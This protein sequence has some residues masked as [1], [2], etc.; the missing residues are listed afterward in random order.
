M[1]RKGTSSVFIF[2]NDRSCLDQHLASRF[3]GDVSAVVCIFVCLL[4]TPPTWTKLGVCGCGS[5]VM[6]PE[7]INPREG[8]GLG[9][10]L[11]D[12]EGHRKMPV[13]R[14]CVT[15][16]GILLKFKCMVFSE[17]CLKD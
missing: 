7:L 2:P 10:C 3:L 5:S 15:P 8:P 13:L 1:K 17:R 16:G 11:F 14:S 4:C 6:D 12:D 9:S